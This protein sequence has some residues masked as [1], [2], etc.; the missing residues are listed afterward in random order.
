MMKNQRI[1]LLIL[2]LMAS[3]LVITVIWDHR[4]KSELDLQVERGWKYMATHHD[5]TP[6][7]TFNKAV[8]IYCSGH[9]GC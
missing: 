8:T 2:L 6:A 1:S 9:A 4:P 3:G 7:E 5:P